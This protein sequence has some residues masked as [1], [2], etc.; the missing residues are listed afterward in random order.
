MRNLLFHKCTK[1]V[2][3]LFTIL[4][5]IGN[6]QSAAIFDTTFGTNGG[7]IFPTNQVSVS[8]ADVAFQSDGKF[9]VATTLGG[10]LFRFNGN[11]TLDTTFGNSGTVIAVDKEIRSIIV[12]N[13]GKILVAGRSINNANQSPSDFYLGRFNSNGTPDQT[14]GNGGVVA[15]DR[16]QSDIFYSVKIQPDG[17]IVAVGFH[18]DGGATGAVIRFNANGSFDSSFADN[19]LFYYPFQNNNNEQKS[20][21]YDVEIMPNGN[22]IPSATVIT[23]FPGTAGDSVGY[24]LVMLDQDGRISTAF[25][26]NGIV[27]GSVAGNRTPGESQI[28]ITNEN[29]IFVA[30]YSGVNVLNS[31]G[32]LY[33]SL[34]FSGN[35]TSKMPNGRILVSGE[36]TDLS[37]G[38]IGLVKLYSE[39]AYIGKAL[40]IVNN[41]ISFAQPDGK[42]LVAGYNEGNLIFQRLNLITSQATR[43][44]DFDFDDKTDLGVYQTQFVRVLKSRGAVINNLQTDFNAK[45]I[46]EFHELEIGY[47][48]PLRRDLVTYY[49]RGT[50]NVSNGRYVIKSESNQT[51]LNENWGLSE[52]IPVGGDY[53]GDAL[54]DLTVFRPS[55]GTWY[56]I[57]GDNRRP[58][59]VKWGTNGD[60]PVPADYDYDG[61]TDYAVYRPSTGTWWILRSSDGGFNVVHFGIASDIPLTG[62][63]D[64][65]GKADFTVYRP[66]EGNWYQLLTTEGFRVTKFGISTDYPVPGDYDGDG[67]H[68]VAVFREG[69]WYILQ[70][71]EGLKI[72]NWGNP[73]DVPVAVRYDQ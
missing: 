8:I 28:E 58:S 51:F 39:N 30:A 48:N 41:G 49:V 52:D 72:V 59:Y 10:Y 35:K 42:I 13:D 47:F 4:F 34:P 2:A 66:S 63:F 3:L 24:I 64:G 7:V 17:K 1:F 65:D 57:K 26:N 18:S 19:G 68:D 37:N 14:F 67:R 62:D 33:K 38:R 45:I 40:N 70:S 60:K 16:S 61:K 12:A 69:V 31:N 71:T 32:T 55:D 21:F 54:T 27:T 6:I 9:I 23:D 36:N 20:G 5:L 15:V 53:N 43:L 44:A 46:P 29:R 50:P 11:G 73:G 25:G 22:I 56:S